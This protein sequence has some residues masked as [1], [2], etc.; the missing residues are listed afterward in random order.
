[1]RRLIVSSSRDK[2]VDVAKSEIL[3]D[4]PDLIF[5]TYIP[6]GT[7]TYSGERRRDSETAPLS[8]RTR[9]L[10]HFRRRHSAQ[11]RTSM[12][13]S[14]RT[15]TYTPTGA[16]TYSCE[17]RRDS[18]SAPLSTRARRLSHFRRRQSSRFRTSMMLFFRTIC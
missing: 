5:C 2:Y 11:F 10:Q 12:M 6:T 3:L 17:R 15:I 13:L 1:M 16:R 9:R 14:I 4:N 18:K 8:T 7:R